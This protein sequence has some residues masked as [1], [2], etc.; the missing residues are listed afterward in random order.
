MTE[1]HIFL[2]RGGRIAGTL[3]VRIGI[4]FP[5]FTFI[6]PISHFHSAQY[7]RPCREQAEGLLRSSA[8]RCDESQASRVS[9]SNDNDDNNN[10]NDNNEKTNQ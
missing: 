10:D 6:A 5:V 3:G 8:A 1:P 4:Y 7:L 2:L 9:D